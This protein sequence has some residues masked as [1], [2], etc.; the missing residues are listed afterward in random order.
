LLILLLGFWHDDDGVAGF[1]RFAFFTSSAGRASLACRAGWAWHGDWYGDFFLNGH[2]RLDHGGRWRGDGGFFACAQADD[3]KHG[4]EDGCF[5]D[6][7]F[8]D[9]VDRNRWDV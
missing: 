7:S 9:V 2:G 6:V 3:G 5:H 8:I 1:A 4:D